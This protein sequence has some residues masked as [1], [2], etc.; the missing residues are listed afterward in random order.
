MLGADSVPRHIACQFV[1]LKRQR[2]PLLACHAAVP[3]DLQSQ[4]RARGHAAILAHATTDSTPF[5]PSHS[6]SG[7]RWTSMAWMQIGASPAGVSV[8][9]WR[10]KGKPSATVT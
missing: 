2:Q 4:S 10:P 3:F 8:S 6:A 5:E 9:V 7:G 1:Q